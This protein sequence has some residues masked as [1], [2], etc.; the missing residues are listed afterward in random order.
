MSDAEYDYPQEVSDPA[1]VFSKRSPLILRLVGAEPSPTDTTN[2]P[3]TRL[4]SSSLSFNIAALCQLQASLLLGSM[5]QRFKPAVHQFYLIPD[6]ARPSEPSRLPRLVCLKPQT[7]NK[8][9]SPKPPPKIHCIKCGIFVSKWQC[10]FLWKFRFTTVHGNLQAAQK[11]PGT[12]GNWC[13]VLQA[14]ELFSPVNTKTSERASAAVVTYYIALIGC[15]SIQLSEEAF[16]FLVRLKR[17]IITAQWSGLRL[18][19]WLELWVWQR[20]ASAEL[21]LFQKGTNFSGYI[22][23]Y[24]VNIAYL[25]EWREWHHCTVF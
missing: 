15:R 13:R 12:P 18:T 16:Y 8:A 24:I 22:W 20:Q 23:W 7:T 1:S 6:W 3:Q 19:F 21:H 5:S 2:V 9:T 25:L 17:P 14:W 10:K 4:I 11:L